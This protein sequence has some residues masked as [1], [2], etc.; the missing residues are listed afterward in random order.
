MNA[1]FPD[2]RRSARARGHFLNEQAAIKCRYPALRSLAPQGAEGNDGPCAENQRPMPLTSCSKTE[3][4]QQRM[5]DPD[6]CYTEFRESLT[7]LR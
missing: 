1:R 7:R 6:P 2:F 3:S 5:T 4:P